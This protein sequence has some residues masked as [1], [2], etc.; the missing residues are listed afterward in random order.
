MRANSKASCL[1]SAQNDC[2]VLIWYNSKAWFCAVAYFYRFYWIYA[3][4]QWKLTEGVQD[5]GTCLY[6]MAEAVRVLDGNS[7]ARRLKRLGFDIR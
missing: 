5:A 7:L 1:Y 2:K 6:T 3:R 4:I